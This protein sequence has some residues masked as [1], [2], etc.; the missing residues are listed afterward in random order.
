MHFVEFC[1]RRYCPLFSD[2]LQNSTNVTLTDQER[3]RCSVKGMLALFCL[4]FDFC[5]ILVHGRFDNSSHFVHVI[6]THY[7]W[8]T[9]GRPEVSKHILGVWLSDFLY[10]C[11]DYAKRV[12]PQSCLLRDKEFKR[13][14]DV[15]TNNL[16]SCVKRQLTRCI[17]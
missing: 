14:L 6:D 1:N 8:A 2:R 12:K 16:P 13:V 5:T 3:R 11:V 9:C 7:V 15:E 10:V 17:D 4:Y